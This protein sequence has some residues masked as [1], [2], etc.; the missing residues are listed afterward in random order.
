[1]GST[2]GKIFK[3]STFGESHGVGIGVVVEGCPAGVDFDTDFI[4][5]ELTRR[6]P[7]QSR[8]TT[9]RKEADEF[10][11][12]SGVFEGKTTG[13]PIALIIRN[14]DQRSKDYSHIAAQFRPSHADYTYQAKYGV[15][16]Y[17]GGGRSS[18]RETAARVAAGALAK[19]L[20]AN[21]GVNIQAYVSQVGGMKL[22]KSYTELDLTETEN[23][24]VRCPDPEMAAAM[25]T[26]IDDVRK[27]GDSIGGVVNCV[28][29]GAPVGWGEPVFDKLHAE[30]GKAMLSIN[31]VKGFE[32]GSGFD[33]VAML[34]SEHNDA[35]YIDEKGDVHT[36]TNH[37]GGI[38][39]GIS[40]GED[41]YF[42][43]AFKPV[44]TI[45][46]DQESVDAQGDVAIVQGKGRHDP[47]VVPRAVPIVEAMAALVL[48][49]F[50]LRNKASKL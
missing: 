20:L 17:R 8:I 41:I 5:S 30:L 2:Y 46:Q 34:G 19:L 21:F 45:M 14:E 40:N 35:F 25:F 31:A 4:Q 36:R 3:I 43:V 37:S 33:G 22:D 16:D 7:G 32:Y 6:K 1:M 15:R 10:E 27:K 44:A 13:T 26:Y 24:A 28:V 29:K 39:G 9:Q 38:Q 12:L 50:Y 11:V 47:C 49:D 18:A 23:N 42:R 48:A